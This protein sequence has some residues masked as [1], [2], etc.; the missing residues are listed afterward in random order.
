M[1]AAAARLHTP[2]EGPED[3]PED[4]QDEVNP[5]PASAVPV[6]NPASA[7]PVRVLVIR[8]RTNVHT[9]FVV[10]EAAA[11]EEPH[12]I[13]PISV[14]GVVPVSIL[15]IA[16]Q[17]ETDSATCV[18]KLDIFPKFAGLANPR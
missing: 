3:T 12:H 16:A 14:V 6:N 4:A 1:T 10:P 13:V 17:Q 11:P 9:L 15:V 5:D 2:S 8:C 7:V 18:V